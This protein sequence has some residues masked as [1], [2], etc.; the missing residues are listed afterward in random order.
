ME[1]KENLWEKVG[2]RCLEHALKLLESETAPT[3]EAAGAIRTLV[4]TAIDIDELNLRQSD[5][6]RFYASVC[7]G[8][9]SL[10]NGAGR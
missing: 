5:Q 1:E 9:F 3:I 7:Q 2:N 10:R 4:E 6:S 8:Q